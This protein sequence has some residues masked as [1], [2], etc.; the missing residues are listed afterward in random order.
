M[1]TGK[2][3][4]ASWWQFNRE[5]PVSPPTQAKWHVALLLEIGIGGIHNEK[6]VSL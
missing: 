4:F 3:I 1:M 2:G 6:E 5:L